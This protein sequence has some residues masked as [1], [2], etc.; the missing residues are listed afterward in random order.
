MVNFSHIFNANVVIP[1]KPLL[2]VPGYCLKESVAKFLKSFMTEGKQAER[3]GVRVR[4]M[5][6]VGRV[7]SDL[8]E[9]LEPAAVSCSSFPFLG[10]NQVS[11]NCSASLHRGSPYV[12]HLTPFMLADFKLIL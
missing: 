10:S 5:H 3:K 2:L 1:G 12:A 8:Y 9:D 11:S 4:W 7:R 6:K